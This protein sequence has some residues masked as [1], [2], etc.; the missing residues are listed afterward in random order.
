[1]KKINKIKH[2]SNLKDIIINRLEIIKNIKPEKIKISMRSNKSPSIT[3][4]ATIE[5]V[6]Y[7][8]QVKAFKLNLNIICNGKTTTY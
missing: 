3:K 7:Y 8:S 4:E 1:M 5:S 2:V 6:I